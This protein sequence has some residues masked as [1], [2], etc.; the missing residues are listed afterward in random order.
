MVETG[1]AVASA[2]GV[3]ETGDENGEDAGSAVVAR[4]DFNVEGDRKV[5]DCSETLMREELETIIMNPLV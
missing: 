3:G 2:A 4:M 1:V 5:E